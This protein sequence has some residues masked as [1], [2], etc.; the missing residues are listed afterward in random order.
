M[1]VDRPASA[2][3]EIAQ[4]KKEKEELRPGLHLLY[5]RFKELPFEIRARIWQL[6]IEPRIVGIIPFQVKAQG[7]SIKS[8]IRPPAA[9]HSCREARSI[10]AP[11]YQPLQI[12]IG[13]KGRI[14][15]RCDFPVINIEPLILFNFK[16]DTLHFVDLNPPDKQIPSQ[17]EVMRVK[18]SVATSPLD[19]LIL[20]E[21]EDPFSLSVLSHYLSTLR[22]IEWFYILEGEQKWN[23]PVRAGD[24]SLKNWTLVRHLRL[25][26]AMFLSDPVLYWSR[27]DTFSKWI[28]NIFKRI[29]QPEAALQSCDI[30]MVSRDGERQRVTYSPNSFNGIGSM[31]QR[32]LQNGAVVFP[33]VH[34]LLEMSVALFEVVDALTSEVAIEKW[35][36]HS[37]KQLRSKVETWQAVGASK[38]GILTSDISIFWTQATRKQRGFAHGEMAPVHGFCLSGYIPN[39][40]NAH[41]L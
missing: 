22:M 41:I 24:P 39:P 21:A 11:H 38:E 40:S 20:K 14:Y 4:D 32:L 5:P 12:A 8:T 31:A 26:F 19:L 27:T 18:P 25:D 34:P 15:H 2:V 7:W 35:S 17:R 30:V 33:D 23:Q 37:R 16:L 6:T 29:G 3:K 28:L 36:E 9:M 13:P 10:I 1:G